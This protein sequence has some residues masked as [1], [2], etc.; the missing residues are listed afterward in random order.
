MRAAAL[1]ALAAALAGCTSGDDDARCPLDP[2]AHVSVCASE[3]D[4]SM[5]SNSALCPSSPADAI[6]LSPACVS[7]TRCSYQVSDDLGVHTERCDCL[8][9]SGWDCYTP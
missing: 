7:G 8:G 2:V 9:E 4:L 1:L 3:A 6:Y 5:P